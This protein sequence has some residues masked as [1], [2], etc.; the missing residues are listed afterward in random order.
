MML[1]N[2]LIV[3][4]SSD[5]TSVIF[6]LGKETSLDPLV[7]IGDQVEV[8]LSSTQHAVAIRTMSRK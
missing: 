2:E 4:K 1:T 7:K 5:G 6:S 8:F 3:V